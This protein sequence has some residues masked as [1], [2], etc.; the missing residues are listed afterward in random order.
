MRTLTRRSKIIGKT[1]PIIKVLSKS[2]VR[3]V[4]CCTPLECKAAPRPSATLEAYRAISFWAFR[5]MPKMII[6]FANQAPV[7]QCKFSRWSTRAETWTC[8]TKHRSRNHKTWT[9]LI[10]NNRWPRITMPVTPQKK[11]GPS[12][13]VRLR[14]LSS[15]KSYHIRKRWACKA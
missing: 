1:Q 3:M 4:S 6:W 8:W 5:R 7:P 10:M 13:W 12:I 2:K 9:K 15:D 11:W 14:T